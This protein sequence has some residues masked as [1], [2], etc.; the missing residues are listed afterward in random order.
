MAANTAASSGGQGWV[1]RTRTGVAANAA[2]SSGGQGRARR[3]RKGAVEEDRGGG[4][5]G[6][7]FGRTRTGVADEDGH[8]IVVAKLK[9][10]E[11]IEAIFNQIVKLIHYFR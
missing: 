5:R 9:K 3:T 4:K 10:H 1:R 6:S 2:A 11:K 7:A 8:R